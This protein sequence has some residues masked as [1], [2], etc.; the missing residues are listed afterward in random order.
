MR[1]EEVKNVMLRFVVNDE[2][3]KTIRG[4]LTGEN[5]VGACG[6]ISEDVSRDF[7][8]VLQSMMFEGLFFCGGVFG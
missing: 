7:F 6:E 3:E 1:S 4:E 2:G 5:N 8:C